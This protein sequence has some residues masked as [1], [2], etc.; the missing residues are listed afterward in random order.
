MHYVVSKIGLLFGQIIYPIISK[1]F[2]CYEDD[3]CYP[4]A[5]IL[6]IVVMICGFII[7]VAGKFSYPKEDK[8][9]N[10]FM[11]SCACIISAIHRKLFDRSENPKKHWLDYSEKSYGNQLIT[12]TKDVLNVSKILCTMPIFWSIYG[13]C[14]SRWVFQANQMNGDLGFY[15]I[16][17]DQ[18]VMLTTLFSIISVPLADYLLYPLLS[19]IGVTKNLQKVTIGMSFA[20]VAFLIA[21]IIE[22]I[23]QDNLISMLWLIPQYFMI[24]LAEVFLWISTLSFVFSV[25]PESMKSVITSLLYLTSAA[26]SLIII[27][28]SGFKLFHSQF[29]EFLV[30]AFMM[31]LTTISFSFTRKN[32]EKKT[33]IT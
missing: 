33:L 25:A 11:R 3:H 14:N 31:I 10:V 9:D 1:D 23:I 15:D 28:V 24:A 8:S 17:P 16:K 30:F 19:K 22:L 26:G 20:V 13:Q 27:F 4:V 6:S 5:F 32:Y 12:D 7:F 2:K 21:A 29:V 18:M